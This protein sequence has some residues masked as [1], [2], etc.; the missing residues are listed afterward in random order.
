MSDQAS[1]WSRAAKAYEDD[2][3]DPYRPDVKSPLDKALAGIK[4]SR[5]KVAADLGC[6][7]GPLLPA[8][9]K[10]FGH[11]YAIDFAPGMLDRARKNC[12]ALDNIE[13]LQRLLT[14]LTALAGKVDVA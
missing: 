13:F 6:G 4:K 7:V 2:F 8:L 10:Q 3:I 5:R 14:D 12:A 1:A 9:S 11:V